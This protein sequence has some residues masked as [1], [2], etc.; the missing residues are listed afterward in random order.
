MDRHEFRRQLD[1][2]LDQHDQAFGALQAARDAARNTDRGFDDAIAATRLLVE[3]LAK[4]NQSHEA[5][6]EAHGKALDAARA[7]NRAALALLRQLDDDG[8]R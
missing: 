6:Y 1:A 7:A 8:G 3:A 4:A 5:I 2:I